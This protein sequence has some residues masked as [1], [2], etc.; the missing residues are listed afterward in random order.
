MN[1]NMQQRNKIDLKKIHGKF[2]HKVIIHHI[3]TNTP[4]Y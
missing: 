2:D 1:K 3:P 4:T